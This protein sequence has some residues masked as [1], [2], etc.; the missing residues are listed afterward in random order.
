[1]NRKSSALLS[2]VICILASVLL[3][4]MVCTFP[5]FLRWLYLSYHPLVNA[6]FYS[7]R[8]AKA[9]IP[10][11]YGCVPFAA[12]ALYMLIRLLLHVL[13]DEIFIPKNVLY[14]RFVSWCCYAVAVIT[15]GFAFRYLPL[16]VVAAAMGVVGTLL[17]VVKNIM[18]A[19][20]EIREENDLTI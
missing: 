17:R 19:A 20:V 6:A 7:A 15:A 18:Q 14:L 8:V 3:A 2:L 4:V 1:M 11:F 5:P 16:I 10:A 9:V 12:A 13:H